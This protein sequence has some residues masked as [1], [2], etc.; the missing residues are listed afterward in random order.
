[1]KAKEI[2]LDGMYYN[3]YPNGKLKSVYVYEGGE[4]TPMYTLYYPI[5]GIEEECQL[6]PNGMQIKRF[7]YQSGSIREI[8]SCFSEVQIRKVL[9]D[10]NGLW[11]VEQNFSSNQLHGISRVYKNEKLI[12]SEMYVNGK[13][14]EGNCYHE[15]GTDMPFA[16]FQESIILNENQPRHFK[17]MKH[18]TSSS[19]FKNYSEKDTFMF[20]MIVR[21]NGTPDSVDVSKINDRNIQKDILDWAKKVSYPCERLSGQPLTSKINFFIV[22]GKENFSTATY[23]PRDL[24]F[25]E[26]TTGNILMETMP[27]YPGG[28]EALRKYL[29]QNIRYPKE[30]STRGIQG[31]VILQFTV[32]TDGSLAG[33]KVIRGLSKETNEEALRVVKN[34]PKWTPGTQKG[35]PVH[36]YFTLPVLFSLK[37]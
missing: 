35:K 9:Y 4:K 7:F 17:N 25:P 21:E 16:P 13:S 29:S 31:R 8:D 27:E 15:D 32:G 37:K 23:K 10:I 24:F 1:M 18:L 22:P 26:Y 20:S 6:S 12:R 2:V 30:A 28:I 34:M 19:S 3:Y 33:I 5:G 11:R 14:T 36:V